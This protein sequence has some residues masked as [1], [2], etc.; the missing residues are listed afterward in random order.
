MHQHAPRIH[1]SMHLV[2]FISSHL[3]TFCAL[4]QQS[5]LVFIQYSSRACWYTCIYL[6][7]C[8][9][10]RPHIYP[11]LRLMHRPEYSSDSVTGQLTTC[12]DKWYFR[13]QLGVASSKVLQRHFC[14]VLQ[15]YYC[16]LQGTLTRQLDQR[17]AKI[18]AYILL[19]G[20]QRHFEPFKLVT[21]HLSVQC[22]WSSSA[23]IPSWLAWISEFR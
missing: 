16:V 22:S 14:I 7:H 3:C 21:G 17:N 5:P 2:H 20:T 6:I 12:Q 10:T 11:T 19:K 23:H 18:K 8:I 13:R 15:L 9:S 4:Y 1:R